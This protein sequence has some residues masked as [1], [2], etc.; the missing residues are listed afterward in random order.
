MAHEHCTSEFPHG[1][2]V[3]TET[4]LERAETKTSM[5]YLSSDPG[6]C[7]DESEK[8]EEFAKERKCVN[9]DHHEYA[10]FCKKSC[11]LCGKWSS[12]S[13]FLHASFP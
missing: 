6:T 12:I 8:C 7:Y 3:L 4:M 10:N 9:H 5:P 1:A 13:P 11:G 2:S